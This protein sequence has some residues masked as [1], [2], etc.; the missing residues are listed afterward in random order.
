MRR[1]HKRNR[2]SALDSAGVIFV[3][4]IAWLCASDDDSGS[5][6]CENKP[7]VYPLDS[8][9]IQQAYITLELGTWNSELGTRTGLGRPV[10]IEPKNGN[11]S[12]FFLL[13]FL[14]VYP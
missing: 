11:R 3:D 2:Y 14:R 13:S 8:R 4:L 10:G 5:V 9:E 1:S 7:S 6:A 12:V